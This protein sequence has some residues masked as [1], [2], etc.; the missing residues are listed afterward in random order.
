[1][2]IFL[3]QPHGVADQQRRQDI[4]GPALFLGVILR[5]G[6]GT[7]KKKN[8]KPAEAGFLS[9]QERFTQG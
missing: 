9:L 5:K 6:A 7:Q 2:T 4:V 1:M 3:L 8:K